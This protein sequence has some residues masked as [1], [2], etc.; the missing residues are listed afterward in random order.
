M[1]QESSG[2]LNMWQESS[3]DLSVAR[4]NSGELR[5]WQE[6]TVVISKCGKILQW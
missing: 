1:W 4:I 5:V 6:S 2:D 3:D